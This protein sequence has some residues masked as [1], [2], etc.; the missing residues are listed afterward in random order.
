MKES[1]EIGDIVTLGV[2]DYVHTNYLIVRGIEGD[3]IYCDYYSPI[4]GIFRT[5]DFHKEQLMLV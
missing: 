3:L 5:I 2:S 1:F 4:D